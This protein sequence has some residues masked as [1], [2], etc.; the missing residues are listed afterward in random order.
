MSLSHCL[1]STFT[2]EI[3][4]DLLNLTSLRHNH[5]V[6]LLLTDIYR[7]LIDCNF[8]TGS[9]NFPVHCHYGIHLLC[10]LIKSNNQKSSWQIVSPWMVTGSLL[11][12]H[13][14]SRNDRW[15]DVKM[16]KQRSDPFIRHSLRRSIMVCFSAPFAEGRTDVLVYRAKITARCQ[17]SG[18]K[19]Y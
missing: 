11:S 19:E 14:S 3:M 12:M 18:R 8:Y 15:Y 9:R 5:H 17:R 1:K 4:P 7:K 16:D 2:D 13:Q 6:K 10:S